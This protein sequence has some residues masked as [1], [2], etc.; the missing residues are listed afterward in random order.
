MR[1]GTCLLYCNLSP[2]A[3][4]DLRWVCTGASNWLLCSAA[5]F[6]NA[7]VADGICVIGQRLDAAFRLH[8][9]NERSTAFIGWLHRNRVFQMSQRT[10]NQAIDIDTLRAISVAQIKAYPKGTF[11]G[12]VSTVMAQPLSSAATPS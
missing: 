4:R 7:A 2:L 6:G 11:F 10:H 5:S 3:H 12:R 1:A 9:T 8:G